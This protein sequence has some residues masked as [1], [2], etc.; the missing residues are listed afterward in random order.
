L[1]AEMDVEYTDYIAFCLMILALL[2]LAF[3]E[4]LLFLS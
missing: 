1:S 4:C 3:S 2:G